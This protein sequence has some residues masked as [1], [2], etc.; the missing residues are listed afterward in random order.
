LSTPSAPPPA[1]PKV[2]G[3]SKWN[4]AR[5]QK[6]QEKE[7][8]ERQAETPL[9]KMATLIFTLV[10][11]AAGMSFLPL[12]PQPVPILLAAIVAFATYKSPRLGM[13][14]GGLIIGVGLLFHLSELY[15]ISFLGDTPARVVFIVVWMTLFVVMPAMFNRYKSALAIDFGILA[16][17]V[18]F[19]DPIFFLAIPL[20]LASAVFFKKYVGLTIVYY[21]LL[22]VPLQLVQYYNYIVTIEQDDW[23]TVAG[24]AP[25]LFVS[26]SSIFKDLASSMSQFRLY[27]ISK[28]VYDI[29]GQTTWIP[30]WT[31]RTIKDAVSQYLDSIP[32]ILMFVIIVAG[33]ALA[34]IFFTQ[35]LV[36]GGII[37]SADRFFPIF[38]ATLA[39]ALF[40]LLLS[41]LQIPLA[42]TAE[43]TGTTMVLGIFATLLFTL[44]VMFMDYSPKRRAT[45]QEIVDKATALLEKVTLLEGQV[46]LVKENLPVI[47]SSPEGKASVLKESIQEIL[48]RTNLHQYEAQELDEKFAELDNLGLDREAIETELNNILN[49]Y[50]IFSSC[51]LSNWVG[52][53]KAAGLAIKTDVK[54]EYKKDMPLEQ[55]IEA[56]KQ[57]LENG[58]SVVKEVSAVAEP[59][60][61]I[62]RPLYDP[63]LPPKSFAVAFAAEKIEKKEAPWKAIEALYN[64][65]N[66]WKRQ[67][68]AEI[69]KSFLYLQNS[70]KPIAHLSGMSEM[71]PAVFGENT[72]KVLDYAKRA[73]G[74]KALAEKR[75]EKSEDKL[76]LQDVVEL[77]TDIDAFVAMSN[78]VLSMLYSELVSHEDAIDRLLP[79]KDYLWEKNTSLK[80]RLS[81]ATGM[82]SDPAKYTINE[83]LSNLPTYLGYIDEAVQTLSFYAERKEFLLNYPL[84]EAAINE[85]LKTKE[86]LLPSDLPFQPRFAAE[87]LRLYYTTR[88]GDYM[89]DKDNLV[90]TRRP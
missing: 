82:L 5:K 48:N 16:F 80:E 55:R 87:Y 86:K 41:A 1:Q 27:D 71:L 60:Y 57:I 15:F 51:E 72:A 76:D 78:D 88:Y 59:I 83:I 21:V 58:K 23:W 2:S 53:L 68:G 66:N 34:L 3:F 43:V 79:T 44:P 30:D 10:A 65:L 54:V 33:L 9:L 47:V 39:A 85:Q 26:L 7:E 11:M 20:I 36:K 31:G 32:G 13:P 45:T 75:V 77:K 81:L 14:F 64:A 28:V 40:F 56:V 17:V 12:L 24:S 52:K 73:D 49:E 25:P 69:Q 29:A 18:L 61:A 67:Y 70:L 8:R 84:A 62:I 4:Q 37:G 50:Q 74:M 90:L 42:F 89:F 46:G 19:F 63:A 38:I 22:S 35:M 6:K